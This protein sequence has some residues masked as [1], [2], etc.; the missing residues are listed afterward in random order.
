MS[1]VPGLFLG[2]DEKNR[3]KGSQILFVEKKK[4]LELKNQVWGEKS[5]EMK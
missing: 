3:C 4:R 1:Q 5:R 2:D